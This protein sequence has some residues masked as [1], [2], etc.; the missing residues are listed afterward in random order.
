[1]HDRGCSVPRCLPLGLYKQ[2]ATLKELL[3]DWREQQGT[4]T[5]QQGAAEGGPADTGA[6]LRATI[7]ANV[8]LAGLQVSGEGLRQAATGTSRLAHICWHARGTSRRHASGW[9][10]LAWCN[11]QQQSSVA[12]NMD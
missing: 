11:T 3:S 4:P 10:S 1:M 12:D 8:Q 5:V 9:F 7:F 2:L 6:G